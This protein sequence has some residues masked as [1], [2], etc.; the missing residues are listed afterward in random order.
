MER[1]RLEVERMNAQNESLRL[2]IELARLQQAQPT[3]G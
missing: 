1:E 2:Q 3:Q